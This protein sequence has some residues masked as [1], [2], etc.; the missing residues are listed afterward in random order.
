MGIISWIK[1]VWSKVFKKEI[2][3]RFGTDT[4]LSDTMERWIQTFYHITEGNPPWQDKGDD[5]ES[6]NFAGFIDDAIAGLV[7]L[8]LGIKMP[9]TPRGKHLQKQAD[10]ILQVIQDKV[11]EAL[12]N[13]GIMFK[14]NG[15]NIDYIEPGNFAPTETDSNGNI[16]GCVFQSQ[17][18]RNGYLYTK[19]EWHRF[20]NGVYEDGQEARVYRISNRAFKAKLP[21]DDYKAFALDQIG[22]ECE[23]SEV[24]EW[25]NLAPDVS[26][27]GIEYPLFA[28]F[29]NPMPNRIDRTSPLG[30]PIWQNCIKELKDLDIAWG[31]K[32]GEVED[33]K[34]IMFVPESVVRYASQHGTKLARFVKSMETGAQLGEDQIHEHVAT[35]LTEQRVADINSIL[36]M[37]S[38]KCG[39]SQGF[40]V[41]DEKTG[42]ITA[43]Q[44]EAD[45][46]ETIDTINNIHTA[47]KD[48]LLNL[49]Y[50]LNV[51]ADIY[52]TLPAET[53]E[54]IGVSKGLKDSIVISYH[55][56]TANPDE[57][58]SRAY[59]LTLNKFYPK[60]YYLVNYEGLSEEEAKRLIEEAQ[61]EQPKEQGLFGEE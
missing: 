51:I 9:D 60:Y 12:G 15:V 11:S 61:A 36:A 27:E 25:A 38:T 56:F 50:A 30:V 53:W 35:L 24:A 52:T 44:V 3:E 39:F 13:C 23:L 40:F 41:L 57:D 34:H 29:K 55:D 45:D 32:S 1:A 4:Q 37:L 21:A 33:S 7:T 5:I 49:F 59:Q 22:R 42:R 19:L 10:Y 20:E 31:R 16:L 47:L 48:S 6:I 28:Y 46:Q 58:R 26:Y 43:T 54:T 2:K 17:I 18:T 8:D 14:P